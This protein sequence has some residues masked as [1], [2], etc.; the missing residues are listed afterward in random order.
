M[1][2]TGV[3]A[4]ETVRVCNNNVVKTETTVLVGSTNKSILI[5]LAKY[6]KRSL[7]IRKSIQI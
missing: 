5:N 3:L 6:I 2:Q 4:M 1:E 7:D